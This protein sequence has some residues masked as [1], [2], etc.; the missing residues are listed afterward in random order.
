MDSVEYPA[1]LAFSTWDRAVS[2]ANAK[3]KP[4]ALGDGLKALRK[5]YDTIDFA[6][7]DLAKLGTP[8]EAEQRRD[9]VDVA[10]ER[11]LKPV[12]D[13]AK[14]VE[15]AA[16]KW[17]GELKKTKPEPSGAISATDAA[18]KG[19]E[20]LARN[21]ASFGAAARFQLAKR[22]A[23]LKSADADKDEDPKL[24]QHK[25]RL[26]A[27]VLEMLRIVK[28]HPEREVKF[29]VCVGNLHCLPYMGLVVGVTQ[30]TLL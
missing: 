14:A 29:V 3:N 24:S 23:E 10:I 19:A 20:T 7:F 1:G 15:Q 18:S 28:N 12:Q 4:A 21:I 6:V 13:Q 5:L 25:L 27:K 16:D 2:A 17:I 8:K 30:K 11:K 9:E 22:I 26:K